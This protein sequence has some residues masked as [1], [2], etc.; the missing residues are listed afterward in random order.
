MLSSTV[1]SLMTRKVIRVEP[2]CPVPDVLKKLHAY[3]ISCVVVC[4]GNSP[5]GMISERDIVGLAYRL[6]SGREGIPQAARDLM[7]SSLITACVSDSLEDVVALIE[8]HHI[9]HLPLVEADGSLAGLITQTDLL[10]A[11]LVEAPRNG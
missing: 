1:N 2:D 8:K 3:R 11:G 10:R 4:E 5:I 7:S 9:R 6:I